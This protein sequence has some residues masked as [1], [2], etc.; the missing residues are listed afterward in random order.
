[1][2][3]II[4]TQIHGTQS[5][6]FGIEIVKD[7]MNY[8]SFLT[9]NYQ[10]SVGKQGFKN[11]FYIYDI[12]MG[13]DMKEKLHQMFNEQKKKF[14]KSLKEENEVWQDMYDFLDTYTKEF[15]DLFKTGKK[16]SK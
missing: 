16:V 15:N 5:F 12:G 14:N 4:Q 2:M 10:Q 13:S 3:K 6:G 11:K 9:F 1:M 7:S 8:L